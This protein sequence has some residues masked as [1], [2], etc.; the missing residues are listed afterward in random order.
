MMQ[1]P[2]QDRS[3]QDLIVEDLT[4]VLEALV[5]GHDETTA[6]VATDEQLEE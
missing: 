5:A 6:L 1:E 4:P 3:G 2:I